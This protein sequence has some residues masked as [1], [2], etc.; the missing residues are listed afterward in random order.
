MN[1]Q[2]FNDP[3]GKHLFHSREVPFDHQD[4]HTSM[5]HCGLTTR[6][7]SS[8]EGCGR[9]RF[10]RPCQV[11]NVYRP[12][13]LHVKANGLHPVLSSH[14]GWLRRRRKRARAERTL[15]ARRVVGDPAGHRAAPRRTFAPTAIRGLPTL[16]GMVCTHFDPICTAREVIQRLCIDL[17]AFPAGRFPLLP[18]HP[19]TSTGMSDT[20]TGFRVSHFH[21]C[22]QTRKHV[23]AC[24]VFTNTESAG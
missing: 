8:E 21:S 23:V 12:A 17:L 18:Q 5:L 11:S 10:R 14:L 22:K 16:F 6:T 4:V 19:A 9:D 20:T 24:H 3:A 13:S 15:T 1:G 7:S 2:C